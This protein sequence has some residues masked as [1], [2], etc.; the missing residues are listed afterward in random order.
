MKNYYSILFLFSVL[1]SSCGTGIESTK[2]VT[3]KDARK[4]LAGYVENAK[5]PTFEIERDSVAAWKSGKRFYVTD[6]R[7][8]LLFNNSSQYNTDSIHLKGKYLTYFGYSNAATLDNRQVVALNFSDGVNQYSYTTNKGIDE[9]GATFEI[10]FFVEED[11][12]KRTAHKLVGKEVYI[13]TAI[14]YKPTDEQVTVGRQFIKVR[15]DSVAPGNKVLPLKILFTALDS[16]EQAAILMSTGNSAIHSR[17]F[18]SLFSW[19][20]LHL[21]YP[22]I[23]NEHWSLIINGQ[24]VESMTKEECRLAKGAP[25]SI[26]SLPD[27]TGVKEYWYYDGG[28]YLFFVDGL[29]RQFRK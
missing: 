10:P 19:K 3:D 17:D 12:V 16:R 23:S 21:N 14:W 1:L 9:L 8:I 20:D 5:Q 6:D 13:K 27:Q 26:S 22:S 29:L 7:S 28:S 2:A 24:V 15:I 18:D 4:I 11:L 25:K